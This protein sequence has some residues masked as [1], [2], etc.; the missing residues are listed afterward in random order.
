MLAET[1]ERRDAGDEI[2]AVIEA[3]ASAKVCASAGSATV[4]SSSS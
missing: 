4:I 1:G 3:R 2:A